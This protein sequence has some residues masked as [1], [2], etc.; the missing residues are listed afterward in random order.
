MALAAK[1]TPGRERGRERW[2]RIA[3]ILIGRIG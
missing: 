1:S 2:Y 3:S